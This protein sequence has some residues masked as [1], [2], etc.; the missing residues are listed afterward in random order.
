MLFR[1]A[2]DGMVRAFDVRTGELRWEF[3]PI[4]PEQREVTGAANVW[5]TISVD[6]Q[7]NLVFLPTTS[8]STDYYGGGRRFD[9]PLAN[10]IV[11]LDGATG[12]VVWSRQVVHHDLFDYDLVG[13]P[14]LVDIV[15]D[16][17]RVPAA[18]LQTKMGWLYGFERTSGRPL[19]PIIDRPVPKTDVPGDVASET[20]P[21][22]LGMAPF[23]HQTLTRDSLFG[24]TPID[25]YACQRKFDALRYD[26][27]YTP[28]SDKGSIFFPSALGGGN[29]GGAAFD[30]TSGGWS[31]GGFHAITLR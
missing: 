4:S 27:M 24:L 25:R 10:S 11:A 3:D 29:W 17:T 8:P 16:G 21:V 5:S 30:A 13:H 18:L 6:P 19:W 22:P 31:S 12:K 14:L 26:G 20:Q 1:Y 15:R 28:P 23:A 9:I 7:R 2:K